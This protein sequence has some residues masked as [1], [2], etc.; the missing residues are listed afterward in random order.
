MHSFFFLLIFAFLSSQKNIIFRKHIF[1]RQQLHARPSNLAESAAAAP[2]KKE[3]ARDAQ[4]NPL[5]CNWL[6]NNELKVTKKTG[7]PHKQPQSLKRNFI[8]FAIRARW[9]SSSQGSDTITLSTVGRF[10][11]ETNW[12]ACSKSL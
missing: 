3:T 2:N 11:H 1:N 6:N 12:D 5:A 8:F 9:P 4:E 10:S 7:A